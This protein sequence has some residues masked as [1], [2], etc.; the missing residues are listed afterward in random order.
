MKEKLLPALGAGLWILGL[1]LS[2]VGLNIHTPTGSWISVVGNV[3]FLVGLGLEGIW[4]YQRWK[5][6]KEEKQD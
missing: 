5:N 6:K 1:V 4:Y 3:T 2:I